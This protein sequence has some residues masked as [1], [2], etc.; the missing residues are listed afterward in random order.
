[1]TEGPPAILIK[2]C[3]ERSGIRLRKEYVKSW[4]D[5]RSIPI[6][7]IDTA[8]TEIVDDFLNKD[9]SI[10]SESV[11]PEQF[12]QLE[13]DAFPPNHLRVGG[14]V[15]LQIQDVDDISN[16]TFSLLSNLNNLSTVRQVYVERNA[17][18]EVDFPRGTLRWT[19]TDGIRQVQAIEAELIPEL[20]LQTPFGTKVIECQYFC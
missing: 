15:V 2:R 20:N 14:G 13:V 12:G 6:T 8:Y 16:S 4:C 10:T 9:M 19:L 5:S 18:D 17:D 7:N 1:M 3:K 11:I